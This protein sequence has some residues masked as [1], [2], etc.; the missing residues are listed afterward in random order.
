ML[1]PYQW[2]TVLL[3]LVVGIRFI[4]KRLPFRLF[5]F[6][7]FDALPML[8][9]L[10]ALL[11]V[12]QAPV[13][14]IALKQSFVL[15]SFVAVYFLGRIFLQTVHDVMQAVPFF[16]LSSGIVSGYAIW[17][18]VQYHAGRESFQVMVGRPNATFSEADWLGL[19]LLVVGAVLYACAL[20]WVKERPTKRLSQPLFLWVVPFLVLMYSVLFLTVARSAWLGAVVVTGFFLG[21]AWW[22]RGA[23][24]LKK[25][26]PSTLAFATLLLVTFFGAV[27]VVTIFHLSPFQF[28]NRIQSTGTGLQRITVSCQSADTALP[29]K[30]VSLGELEQGGCRFIPLEEIDQE[31]RAGHFIQEV[32]RDDPNVTIRREI[33]GRVLQVV[34]IQPI[35]GVGWGSASVF[36]GTDER[37]AGLNASNMFLEVWLGSGLVG[38]GA[39]VV[40]WILAFVSAVHWYFT[41]R[42][43]RDQIFALFLA[44]TFSGVTV[45]NLFNS[46]I[47]LGF[48]FLLLALGALAIEKRFPVR[49]KIK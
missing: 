27:A 11:A 46:G 3:L 7:F 41:A 39:F 24:G 16:L 45:F 22:L 34:A 35:L 36:L 29:Q 4:S 20:W 25:E 31:Q 40:W 49:E 30:I 18:N 15:A 21:G 2:L 26:L 38:L 14:S 43:M 5:R 47:L 37:G 12:T 42:D 6:R 32:Y 10:G 48:F 28:W 23:K 17:Q 1:R 19:F 8:L 9:F 33:Y 13:P 44:A